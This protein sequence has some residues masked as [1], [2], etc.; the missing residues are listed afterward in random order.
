MLLGTVI[1]RVVRAGATSELVNLLP[2]VINPLD[3]LGQHRVA[4]IVHEV[5]T[6]VLKNTRILTAFLMPANAEHELRSALGDDES[7]DAISI[8]RN[9]TVTEA[10]ELVLSTIQTL[11]EAGDPT[12]ARGPR[13]NLKPDVRSR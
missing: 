12:T 9:L 3:Q 2:A 10:A 7:A 4:T 1:R 8:G 6:Q 13:A 5:V 11:V